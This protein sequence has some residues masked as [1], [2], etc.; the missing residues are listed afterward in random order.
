M[1]IEIDLL[2]NYPKIKRDLTA[3]LEAK[4]D[5][6]RAMGRRFGFDYFDGDRNHG[7]GG[8]SYQERFWKPVVPDLISHFSL[9]NNSKV[10]DVGCAKGFFLH[11]L[12]NAIPGIEI[13][14]VD[15]SQYAIENAIETVS[16]KVKVG[17]ARNLEFPDNSFDFVMSIN[18]I[19]NLDQDD[20]S[21]AL[22]EI[23]R[24]SGGRAFITVDAYRNEIEKER[25]EAWNLTA[26]TMMS[27]EEWKSFF[28]EV[29]YD[30]DYF[31]FIP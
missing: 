15:I 23:Q 5:E 13:H 20:C 8:F 28:K 22:R 2:A 10:L 17:D 7:Y 14:G 12:Q 27:V 4:S 24:V 31:W 29:G 26:L 11:D 6:A 3:R 21:R 25:M 16:G 30:G 1:G 18:V 9:T 19:H